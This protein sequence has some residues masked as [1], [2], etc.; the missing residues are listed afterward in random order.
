MPD[1][2]KDYYSL[3]GLPR[4]VTSDEIR[5]AYLKAAKHLHPDVNKSPGETEMFM[6]AQQAYQVLS[7]PARRAAYDATLPPERPIPPIINKRL[8]VSRKMLS[9]RKEN[10]LVYLLIE[11]EAAKEYLGAASF[12]PLNICLALDVSTSM[13]GEKLEKAKETALH[14]IRKLRPQDIFSVVAFNDRAEVI[15]PASRQA[16]PVKMENSIRR[17][18]TSGGTE[19]LNGLRVALDEVNRYH[20]PKYINQII[21]LT[22]GR[23]YG[24]EEACY[25]LAKEAAIRGTGINGLGIGSGW[26][27]IFL[28]HL[29]TLTGGTSTLAPQP[30][31]IERLLMEK[32]SSIS[33]TFAENVSLEYKLDEGIEINYAFRLLPVTDPLPCENPLRMGPILQ[34]W[35]FSV[36]IEFVVH[37]REDNSKNVTLLEGNFEIS[38][39]SL[40][41]PLRSIPINVVLSLRDTIELDSPPAAMIQALSKLTLYRMQ[42][43]ARSEISRGNYAQGSEHLQRLATRLLSQGERS[44][45]KTIMLEIENIETSNSISEIGEKQIKYGT[46]GLFLPEEV[47]R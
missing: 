37:P 36:L 43:K 47:R 21:L 6:T 35:P 22:D 27:D 8:L 30:Q 28:D 31:D 1:N 34:A 26:N 13:K 29:A 42:E 46:R 16:N 18:E 7:D 2:S 41:V 19:M 10:Q 23:T 33:K 5:H 38:V 44:L 45:A 20:N 15:I 25:A 32:F 24:D 9:P 4:S 39:N 14:L 11:M 12:V 3:L 40:D 17:I